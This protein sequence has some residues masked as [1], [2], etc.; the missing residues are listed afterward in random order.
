MEY[1]EKHGIDYD[2]SMIPAEWFGWMHYKTDFP[3]TKVP[4]TS[5]KWMQDHRENLSGTSEQYVPY[6]TTPPK[7][8]TWVP[9]KKSSH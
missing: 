1:N 6:T 5:Y 9:P 2:G 7:I 4:P 8:Q 3:P